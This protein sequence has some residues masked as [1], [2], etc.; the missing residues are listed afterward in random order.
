MSRN[1]Y[2]ILGV[3]ETASQNEIKAAYKAKTKDYHP[4]TYS[5]KDANMKKILHDKFVELHEAYEILRRN[6]HST[7]HDTHSQRK[8]NNA[9]YEN[10]AAKKSERERKEAEE[11]RKRME[12]RYNELI[13]AKNTA[14]TEREY[15]DL[16]RQFRAMNGYKNTAELA[17]DCDAQYRALK[18]QREEQERI[19]QQRIA[20]QNRIANMERMVQEEIALVDKKF[21]NNK[22]EHFTLDIREYYL[23][24]LKCSYAS[25]DDF[26]MLRILYD[27]S[28][29]EIRS[30]I[31]DGLNIFYFSYDNFTNKPSEYSQKN[32][33]KNYTTTDD[34]TEILDLLLDVSF[35]AQ[36][37]LK[38][39]LESTKSK[40]S[41]EIRDKFYRITCE[42][43]R[44]EME[45]IRL[46]RQQE[47]QRQIEEKRRIEQ[48]QK[49]RED[50]EKKEFEREQER[51]RREN[52]CE[53]CGG[54]R[55]DTWKGVFN[56][57]IVR[58]DCNSCKV[59]WD[60]QG[61]ARGANG[62]L[63]LPPGAGRGMQKVYDLMASN[64]NARFRNMAQSKGITKAFMESHK[65]V[66]AEEE[67]IYNYLTM[68]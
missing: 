47:E 58:K 10:E 29:W 63:I 1:P 7:S 6:S 11:A 68:K 15:Q 9:D 67:I 22:Y 51:R 33:E 18:I 65:N 40:V 4:D 42:A 43:L 45:R 3:A 38:Q 8:R 44:T 53:Y 59:W 27:K 62:D 50:R 26:K 41:T 49:E 60:E 34:N 30:S 12:L 57:R 17:R 13:Y 64:L 66:K 54:T 36:H 24:A 37:Q 16:A 2:K 20:E 28:K 35:P 61:N 21:E 25:E 48:E 39:R 23:L 56:K 19:E 55:R 31:R 5:G 52:L 32:W 14:S 46:E